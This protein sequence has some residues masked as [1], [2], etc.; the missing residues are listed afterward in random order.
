VV[1]TYLGVLFLP[2][3]ALTVVPAVVALLAGRFDVA[4]RYGAVIGLLLAAGGLCTRLRRPSRIQANEALVVTASIFAVS[5]L[6]MSFPLAAYGMHPIDAVFEAVSGVTTTGLSTLGAI[7]DRP[8]PLLF[9][10]AWLQWVGGLGVVVLALAMLIRPG[11]AAKRLGFDRREMDDLAGG[12]RAHAKRVLVAYGLLTVVGIGLVW[13]A[14]ATW[15]DA[16][17]HVLAG[18][19]TGGFSTH[20]GSLAGIPSPWA[21]GA[22]VLVCFAGALSFTWY[23]SGLYRKPSVVFRDVRIRTLL[24][25][26]LLFVALIQL[27]LVGAAGLPPLEALGHAALMG[28]SAQ[29]TAGFAS[30]P[31]AELPDVAKLLL[32]CSMIT[33]GAVGSTAGGIK[34]LRVLAVVLLLGSLLREVSTP[35]S[36]RLRGSLGNL[37]FRPDELRNAVAVVIAYGSVVLLSWFVFLSYGH[38]PLDSLF[39]IVSATATA[40]LSAGIVGPGLEPMLKAVL[41]ID[42]L[43]GRVEVIAVLILF[44]PPTWIGKRRGLK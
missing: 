24:A 40:G 22:I 37:R 11:T 4:W 5:S 9:A 41:C 28:L 33:G 14:G 19:S 1:A 10:R 32:I 16:V 8:A 29:T 23:Y 42:M 7:E 27:T 26:C 17:V 6:V 12:T 34:I 31:V 39:E 30:L 36:S 35:R 21:R 44:F 13:F 38:D 3:A 20:D 18:I 15:F 25:L 2:L 43:M